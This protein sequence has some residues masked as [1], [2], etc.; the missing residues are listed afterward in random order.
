MALQKS[1]ENGAE[2]GFYIV[3]IF[4]TDVNIVCK[5]KN[6]LSFLFLILTRF[7][8]VVTVIRLFLILFQWFCRQKPTCLFKCCK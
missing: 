7:L 8:I 3:F 4:I 6:I 5:I 2:K 1:H